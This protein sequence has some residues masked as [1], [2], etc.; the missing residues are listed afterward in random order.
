MPHRGAA[1]PFSCRVEARHWTCAP[2]PTLQGPPCMDNRTQTTLENNRSTVLVGAGAPSLGKRLQA[3]GSPACGRGGTAAA[4]VLTQD[5]CVHGLAL[6]ASAHG[7]MPVLCSLE[8]HSRN[9]PSIPL[10]RVQYK[11][12]NFVSL[13]LS[14]LYCIHAT[15]WSWPCRTPQAMTCLRDDSAPGTSRWATHTP[16]RSQQSGF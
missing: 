9:R 8:Q 1:H 10:R 12:S 2:S 13:T 16:A 3:H 11:K 5:R 4:A 7:A 6:H 15:I 14:C